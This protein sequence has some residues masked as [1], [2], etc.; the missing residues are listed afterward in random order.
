MD[1]KFW[2]PSGW[3]FL[4]TITFN[5]PLS[6]DSKNKHHIS[7]KKYI[8]QLFENLKFTLPCKY[9]RESFAL[10]LKRLPINKYL[11]GR[12]DL[13]WWLYSIHNMVNEKLRKQEQYHFDK[14]IKKMAAKAK[15]SGWTEKRIKK[16]YQTLEKNI[17][18]TGPDPTFKEVCE[19][20]EKHRA[21]CSAAKGIKV[22]KSTRSRTK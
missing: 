19:K 22:C 6:I 14:E 8:K 1:T 10:F 18:Y 15:K 7:T 2:G 5:Y 21:S 13:T 17:L 12:A 3:T 9:C 11:G 20:Y 16:E 4:H